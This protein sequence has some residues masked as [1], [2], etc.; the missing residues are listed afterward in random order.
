MLEA[1]PGLYGL[2]PASV[3]ERTCL[4]R[5]DDAC[6][7]D[8]IW[9]RE[10][11]SGLV[12]GL[13]IGGALGLVTLSA[14][15]ASSL[16]SPLSFMIGAIGIPVLAGA[17][18]RCVDLSRQLEAV[19][20]ARRG[21]LALLD[22]ADDLLASK[23]DAIARADAKLDSDLPARRG[24][25]PV[26][27]GE[28]AEPTFCERD[29]RMYAAALQIF[30]V[31]GDLER[32]LEEQEK[33]AGGDPSEQRARIR[34]IRDQA[35]SIAGEAAPPEGGVCPMALGDL[36]ERALASARPS[37]ARSAEIEIDCEPDLPLVD[38]EPVQIEQVVTQLL[39][40]AVEAS[41]GL[42]E[43][44]RVDVRLRRAPGGVELAVEDRG[45]GLDSSEIDEV[46]DPF[47][48]ERPLGAESGIGLPACLRIVE[49]HG[50]EMR[51]E[52]GNRMGTRVSILFPEC[53]RSHPDDA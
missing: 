27:Q 8:V 46:F 24:S 53:G 26:G 6:R 17:L 20:G 25:A 38:C 16:V 23:I 48:A 34:E 36:V 28:A 43:M 29:Q 22:Q 21:Q 39:Q 19:A 30:S 2:L 35:A 31:A 3:T 52:T 47:F 50:G 49:R 14:L 33:Q 9:Q 44:P 5:G 1:I 10:V 51:I 18:G 45:A 40:N 7:Y 11:R 37:L 4:A 13:G 12:V 15:A 42:M 32:A 41:A